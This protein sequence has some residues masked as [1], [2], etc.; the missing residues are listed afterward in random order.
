MLLAVSRGALWPRRPP[1]NMAH[2]WLF[3][4]SSGTSI[5]PTVRASPRYAELQTTSNFS[6][7]RG[8]SHPHEL[9]SAAA[10]HGLS[11]LALTDRNTLAG[12]VRGHVAAEEAGLPYIV[13]CRLDLEDGPSLLCYPTDRAAYGRLSH[14]LTRGKRK[15]E[16]GA[17]SLKLEDV[18]NHA[19][20]QVFI[21]LPPPRWDIEVLS[22]AYRALVD[23]LG[24]PS[25][26]AA[27]AHYQGDDRRRIAQLAIVAENCQAPLIA[28]GDVLY[29][30]PSRRPLQDVVTCIREHCTLWQAGFRLQ[31][32]GERYVRTPLDMARLFKGHDA[33]LA[34]TL[35]VQQA[36]TFSLSD[37]RYNYPREPVPEA[38]SP[39]QHLEDL[40]WQGAC[41]RFPFG[42]PDNVQQTLQKELTLI[43]ELNFPLYFLTVHD[44][45]QWAR[46]RGILCQGRGSA[47]NSAVCYCLHITSVDPTEIDLLFERFISRER[48]E[49]P[50][51][52]VDFEHER[53]EEVMQYIYQRYGREHAG[54]AATVITYRTRSSV[55][56]VGKVMGLSEDVTAALAGTVWGSSADKL[57]EKRVR[58]AGLDPGD[59]TLARAVILARALIGFPRHLSQHVGGFVLTEDP[60]SE[61][62]PIGNAAME[63]RTFV[64]WDKDDLDALGILKI[65]VLALGM[66]TC[67]QKCLDLLAYHY[68]E[69]R[70]LA[71]FFPADDAETFKMIQNA[72]TIGVFQIESR[73]QMSMLPRLKPKNFYDL[74]I[75]IAIVRPG[76]IQGGMVHP[77]LKRRQ[78]LEDINI[79]SPA[80]EHGHPDELKNVLNKTLGVP[81]FQEQAMSLAMKAAQFTSAELNGL[82]RAMATFRRAG[83][84]HTFEEKMVTRMVARGYE[85]AFAKR[86]FDQIKGFAEY[87]FPE[88]HSASFALLAYVSSWLKCH[89]PDVFACALLNAQPMGF[90]APAQ[91]V[92]DAREHGV[93]VRPVDVNMSDWDNTLEPIGDGSHALRLGMRQVDGLRQQDANTLV[94]HRDTA[95]ESLQQIQSLTRVRVVSLERLAD[96]DAFRSLGLDRRQALWQV[97]GLS[98]AAPLPLFAH[99]QTDGQGPDQVVTLPEMALSEHVIADYQTLRLSLKAHPMALLRATFDPMHCITTARVRDLADKTPV[100]IAGVILVRQRPG[101]AKG[102]MFM[103]LEDETGVA[104]AVIWPKTFEAYRKVAM[105]S[106]L[107]LLRGRIQSHDGVVHVV[108][109]HLEDHSAQL[110]SLSDEVSGSDETRS[111]ADPASHDALRKALTGPNTRRHPRNARVIPN[112]RDFH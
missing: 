1:A 63:E 6:F 25:F 39:Q 97:R 108:T 78:G 26:L 4:M 46:G 23:Q 49:A 56:E 76:P 92:R 77:Y 30:T 32:N 44:I 109:H 94:A 14:L 22:K 85:E 112:S 93:E 52:D 16:K 20:G 80:P 2:A 15:S 66:L 103:T 79:P 99:T 98:K 54:I 41:K 40:T 9:V 50:D 29:H 69:D 38:K 95:F 36:C 104:N 71:S 59:T 88:S 102:V 83:T 67:I 81:L 57:A 73:A 100:T 96:A 47:A 51:I 90:Y 86:C 82:R 62:V 64:E 74:V 87:G 72:D 33:A 101:T 84:I 48:K 18:Y 13:G 37:L 105:S 55:R 11:A 65:D 5:T 21:L 31:A 3:L 110:V 17:C 68:G 111:L 45:V 43:E 8:A 91:I 12:V 58:E 34:R 28:T 24:V 42:I 106:R 35:E 53:R 7:L 19:R 75:E 61:V 27:S 70:D 107:V 60:L 89:R 10:D